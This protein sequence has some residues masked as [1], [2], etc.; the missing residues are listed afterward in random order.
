MPLSEQ[1]RK[2]IILAECTI[3]A[4][5]LNEQSGGGPVIQI[6]PTEEWDK[7][8]LDEADAFKR[9]LRDMARSLGG[10]NNR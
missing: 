4:R 2:D 10:T 5:K 8:T 7:L 6:P 1:T 3:L 9:E